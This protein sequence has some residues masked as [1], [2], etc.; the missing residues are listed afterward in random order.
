MDINNKKQGS[1]LYPRGPY[2]I[3]SLDHLIV[4]TVSK[5]NILSSLL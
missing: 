2:D 4:I 1:L 5:S 3:V